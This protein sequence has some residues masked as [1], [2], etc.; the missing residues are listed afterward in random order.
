MD[1][2]TKPL[3]SPSAS[4]R[5]GKSARHGSAQTCTL[6]PAG[7]LESC[8]LKTVID[9]G[10]PAL[11]FLAMIVV[12]ME[13]TTNDF[14]RVARR[15]FSV[16]LITI[17][18]CV[19]LPVIGWL[20]ARGLSLQRT[21]AQGLVL[22][23]ACP[24]GAMANVYTQLGGG[25]V[26]LSV[27]LT[28]VSCLA[29]MLTTPI[30]LAVLQQDDGVS[31]GLSVPYAVLARQLLVLLVVPIL[32]GMAIRR[33][34]PGIVARYKRLLFGFNVVA[35][36]TLL[37]FVIVHEA[38]HLTSGLCDLVLA[39]TLLTALAFG[40]GWAVSW[41]GGGQSAD[42]FAVGMVFVVRNVGIATAIAVTAL[43]H[44]E[45][46]AFGTAYFVAQVPLL[47]AVVWGFRRQ[48][49]PQQI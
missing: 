14:R 9:A 38:D 15:P 11:V 34:T 28:A 18:Q 3:K 26:A 5:L 7:A 35:L 8:L 49:Q 37:G 45:F 33:R 40:T 2:T 43:G 16:A 46:A 17:S 39:T 6:D 47:L 10:V 48:R 29:A 31:S 4:I 19:L 23:V 32:V 22:V 1:G 30:A 21:I 44:V 20:L 13:L 42:R 25:N 27:A 36:V 12:G 24:S 41:A